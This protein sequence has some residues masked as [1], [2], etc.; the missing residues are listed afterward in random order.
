MRI[1]KIDLDAPIHCL[2]KIAMFPESGDAARLSADDLAR[3]RRV[4][5][6]QVER[7]ERAGARL[8]IEALRDYVEIMGGTMEIVVTLPR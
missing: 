6:E 8:T 1:E 2:R 3:I 5:V 7:D 4:D